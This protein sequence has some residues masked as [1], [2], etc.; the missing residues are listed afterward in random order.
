M[1]T[2]PDTRQSRRGRL[3]RSSNAENARNSKMWRTDRPTDIPTDL[4]TDTARC[5]VA[6]LTLKNG[7]QVFFSIRSQ[8]QS[9]DIKY[10]YWLSREDRCYFRFWRTIIYY[11]VRHLYSAPTTEACPLVTHRICCSMEDI[12]DKA[13]SQWVI[14]SS[15]SLTAHWAQLF[16]D[17]IIIMLIIISH[18]RNHEIKIWRKTNC[19]TTVVWHKKTILSLI[20]S[21]HNND[22][23]APSFWAAMTTL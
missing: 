14:I 22:V 7:S 16:Y 15:I 5:R 4:A 13:A 6:C 21:R 11:T 1:K 12:C 17:R 9:K 8:S 19:K 23:S 10:A 3:G 2:R 20:R 18:R